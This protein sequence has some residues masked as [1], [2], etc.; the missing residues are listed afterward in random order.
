MLAWRAFFNRFLPDGVLFCRTAFAQSSSRVLGSVWRFWPGL[1]PRLWARDAGCAFP[2]APSVDG[3]DLLAADAG[4][5]RI[6]VAAP[7]DSRKGDRL[8]GFIKF[9]R[10][11]GNG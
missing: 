3:A 5:V 6:A 11:T 8:T 10:C 2:V 9:F 4:C 7:A 1:C